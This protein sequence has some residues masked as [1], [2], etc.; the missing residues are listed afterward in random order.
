ME[1]I[2]KFIRKRSDI[3]TSYEVLGNK[4]VKKNIKMSNY[5]KT[6]QQNP[7]QSRCYLEEKDRRQNTRQNLRK[8]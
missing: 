7:L 4:I 1:N 2:L 3:K 6:Q 8:K 5:K